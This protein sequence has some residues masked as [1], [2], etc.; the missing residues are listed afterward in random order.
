MVTQSII[1]QNDL[2][3]CLCD[4]IVVDAHGITIDLNGHP[5]DGKGVGAAV[6]NDG[7]DSVTIRNGSVVDCD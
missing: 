5:I 2:V 6:R 1:V 7:F 4:G 3:D